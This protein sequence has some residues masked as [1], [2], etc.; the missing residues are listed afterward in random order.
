[1]LQALLQALLQDLLQALGFEP[2]GS[3]ASLKRSLATMQSSWVR[4]ILYLAKILLWNNLYYS[5]P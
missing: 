5:R 3:F 4:H 2:P 1:M